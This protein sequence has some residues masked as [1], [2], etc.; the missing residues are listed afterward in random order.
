MD[1]PGIVRS[2]LGKA[3]SDAELKAACERPSYPD[4]KNRHQPNQHT[5]SKIENT[6]KHVPSRKAKL[7][8]MT[9]KV[10]REEQRREPE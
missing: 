7:D 2:Y 6:S 4:T 9:Q 3:R 10:G 8:E 5:K 1:P